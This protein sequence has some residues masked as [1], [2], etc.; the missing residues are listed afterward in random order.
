MRVFPALRLP[1]LS[2]A[3]VAG[4]LVVPGRAAET[5]IDFNAQIRP[6]LNQ[7]CTACHGGVKAAGDISFV[8]REVKNQ[9]GKKSGH[10][11]IVP[12]KPEESEM[13]ARVT[14]TDRDYRMPPAEHGAAL[15]PE[16]IALLRE[17]IKQGAPWQDH[18]AFV[19]PK[20]QAIPALKSP[21]LAT[22]ARSPLDKF[23]A[24]RLEREQLA[25]AP[26]APRA[27]WLRRASLDLTGLPPTPEEIAAFAADRTPNAFAAQVDRLLASPRFGE[28]WAS[29]WLDL[30]R[31]ADT[32]G[33][34][35]DDNRNVWQYRDWLVGAFNR[36]LPYDRFIVEQLAG[37]LLPNPKIEQKVATAFHRLT[38]VNDEG[39][40]D[41]EEY[42]IAA[43]IDRVATT[44]QMTSAVTF[45]CVQCHSHPYDPIRHEEFYKFY[46][47]FNETRDADFRDEIPTMR[48]PNDPARN[49]EAQRLTR[50]IEAL[51]HDVVAAGATLE[52]GA[53]WS[54]TPILAA[55]ALPDA[56]ITVRDGAM[57]ADGTIASNV[58][59]ELA[60]PVLA[61]SAEPVTA[62]RIEVRPVEP[63]KAIHTPERGF[64]VTQLQVAL[65]SPDGS[66]TPLEV[67]R[68]FPDT[69]Y[70]TTI[71]TKAVPKAAAVATPPVA[72]ESVA[73]AVPKSGKKAKAATA[74]A[75]AAKAGGM[76]TAAPDEVRD[77]T[78]DFH[79]AA[80]PTISEARWV[81]AALREPLVA[82]PGSTIHVSVVHG[83]QITEKPA[84]VRRLRVATSSDPRW[85]ALARDGELARKSARVSEAIAELAKIPGTDLPVMAD[86]PAR[87]R[88]ET[89]LFRRGNFLEKIG[90]P[91]QPAVPALFPPLP[92]GAPANRLTLAQ[93]F[94]QPGQP[95]TARVAVNR[96]WEQ[97]FGSGIV[98][99]LEDFGSVGDKPSH[100]E[101]LDWLALHFERDLK[102]DIKALLREIALSATY[103]QDAKTRPELAERDPQNRLLARGPRQRL[104]AEMVRDQALAASGLLSAKMGGAPVMPPQPDG[105][106][107]TVY[108]SKNWEESQGEDRYRRALYTFWKRSAAYPGFLSFDMPARDLCTARRTPTNTPLQALVTLNDVVYQEAA[109]ALAERVTRELSDQPAP[110]ARIAR[111]FELVVSRPPMA[112]EAGRLRKLYDDTLAAE[113]AVKA[114]PESAKSEPAKPELHALS[115]VA[116]AIINLDGAF[117]R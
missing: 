112:T 10:R 23:V 17:W 72:G 4:L 96:F 37:D 70:F 39:G 80:N 91:L 24:A 67:G 36:D 89:R 113:T 105:V 3:C 32:K 116:A 75:S 58:R 81:V 90:E 34:E 41:D 78:L 43:V 1:S 114:A 65:S 47:F 42:R 103:R 46:A 60:L 88:R 108:N 106:W 21:A 98:A 22:W 15:A 56:K 14:S 12:G 11:V 59:Y 28:R 115:D 18:W 44:W 68:Y 45:N 57:E 48:V 19:P 26:E 100:P 84:P 97:M 13:I 94:F 95:L 69:E 7:N 20:P 104:T 109:A 73:K 83:R 49:D 99:T 62:L 29:L 101:L 64:I 111:A 93:W 92:A 30:G 87:E 86:L 27:A 50:E 5:P 52:A 25:P 110:D 82:P 107:Q 77:V 55:R 53:P 9:V 71:A 79:F 61:L 66:V 35:K 16:K 8:Y 31:Y 2:L 85:N 6:I 33:Y 38:Q 102:W 40:S 117:V 74:K 76:V 54:P 51:R 63:E